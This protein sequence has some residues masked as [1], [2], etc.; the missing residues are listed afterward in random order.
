MLSFIVIGRNEEKNLK[1]TIEGIIGAAAYCRMKRYEIIY[2]DSKSTDSSI[3]IA[4]QFPEVR[5]FSITGETNAAIGR[6]IGA[7]EA[8][9]NAFFF[10]DGDMKII[11]EFL[12]GVWDEEKET[13]NENFVSGQLL[14]IENG[15]S[16]KR[17]FNKILPG[18]I[19]II[20]RDV[21]EA[22]GGMNTKFT[23]GEDYDLGLRLR[24]KGYIFQRKPEIITEHYTVPILDKSRIW[25]AMRSK[26]TFYPRCVLLRDHLFSPQMYNLLWKN[27]K[28]FI[29]L[30]VTLLALIVY[31]P[32]GLILLAVYLISIVLRV[33]QQKK[34]LPFFQ[35]LGYFLLFDFLNLVYFFTFFPKKRKEEYKAA[36][37]NI[38][39]PA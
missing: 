34:Y 13:I 3:A 21:W 35:L 7:K 23:A 19:F 30:I 20:K 24:K 10:I 36:R 39:A 28:T 5:I 26:Y 38:T 22:V 17:S 12:K 2:V 32:V 11:P 14:D 15:Q 29:L 4:S 6:N 16:R 37:Q 27:D 8:N 25:K 33:L 18:G 9:G 31:Y 1:R